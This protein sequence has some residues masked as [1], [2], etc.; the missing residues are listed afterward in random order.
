MDLVKITEP[1]ANKIKELLAAEETP[2]LFL[3]L[4]VKPGGCTGFTYGMG[5]DNEQREDDHVLELHGMKVVVD[6]ESAKFLYGL[7]IDYQEAAMG[8][9]FTMNNPNAVATCGCGSS[10]RTATDAGKPD[11]EC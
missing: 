11:T 5:F 9:G 8:G 7:E 10:F 1:A 4:G 6:P 2:N 3:R